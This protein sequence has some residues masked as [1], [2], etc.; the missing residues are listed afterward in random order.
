MISEDSKRYLC[1]ACDKIWA[2]DRLLKKDFDI[3]I[4]LHGLWTRTQPYPTSEVEAMQIMRELKAAW[5]ERAGLHDTLTNHG[6]EL[7]ISLLAYEMGIPERGVPI[8]NK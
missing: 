7:T 2:L 3:P 1:L 6:V 8:I 4:K 5:D